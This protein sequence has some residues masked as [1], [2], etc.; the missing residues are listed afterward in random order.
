MD[1]TNLNN[2]DLSN[3]NLSTL[4]KTSFEGL[5]KLLELDLSLNS[6]VRL[7][8]IWFDP[9]VSLRSLTINNCG[10]RYFEPSEFKWQLTLVYLSMKDNNMTFMP[11]LPLET[12]NNKFFPWEVHLQRNRIFCSCRR[13]SIHRKH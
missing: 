8:Q 9:L 7:K 10:V 13:K 6:F 5:S 12:S 4:D 1:F 3:C 2:L 11:P